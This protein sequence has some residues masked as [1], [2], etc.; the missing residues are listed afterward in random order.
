MTTDTSFLPNDDVQRREFL[1]LLATDGEI[2]K[3][4]TDDIEEDILP[5]AVQA[6]AVE[7]VKT[8]IAADE[9]RDEVEGIKTAL[10]ALGGLSAGLLGL[11]GGSLE[12]IEGE[13]EDLMA[14]RTVCRDQGAKIRSGA[15][16]KPLV[17]S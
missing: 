8:S 15:G 12:R 11:S 2:L 1:M 14:F 3:A 6:M 16:L 4:L 10:G 13:D 7:L 9:L 5:F 17:A